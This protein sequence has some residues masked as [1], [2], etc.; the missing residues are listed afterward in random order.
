[1]AAFALIAFAL[2]RSLA[3]AAIFVEIV[4]GVNG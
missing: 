4:L 1:M 3:R 2:P